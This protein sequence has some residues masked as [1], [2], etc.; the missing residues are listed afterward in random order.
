MQADL[1]Y[2]FRFDQNEASVEGLGGIRVCY[3]PRKPHWSCHQIVPEV[4]RN[5]AITKRCGLRFLEN[6]ESDYE[7]E[8]QYF[9]ERKDMDIEEDERGLLVLVNRT[10][11]RHLCR[12]EDQ[13]WELTNSW[14]SWTA[15]VNHDGHWVTS[16]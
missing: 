11:Q 16:I 8:D 3:L 14:L 15:I 9:E 12:A 6:S 13:V 1:N 5:K 4:R 2:T 10:D 7:A